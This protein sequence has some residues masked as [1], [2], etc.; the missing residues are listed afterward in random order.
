MAEYIL[1]ERKAFVNW[2][3]NE[4]YKQL[5]V[6][7]KGQDNFKKIYQELLK[8]FQPYNNHL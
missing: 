6:D 7:R 1:P 5:V 8:R 4:F 3:N 2:F